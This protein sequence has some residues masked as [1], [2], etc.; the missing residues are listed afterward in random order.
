MIRRALIAW[1]DEGRWLWRTTPWWVWA[2]W[3]LA[4][5][6]M[7]LTLGCVLAGIAAGVIVS[8]R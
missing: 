6:W 7:G 8:I 2:G 4:S 5:I 3:L 1:F